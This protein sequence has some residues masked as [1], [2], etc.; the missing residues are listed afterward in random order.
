MPT[1]LIIDDERAIRNVLKDILSNEGFKVEEA[2]DGEEGLKKFQAGS[3]DVVLCDIKMPKLDGIEFLQKVMETGT[4]IPVI[5]ISGH[6]NIETAVDAVKKGAFDY[7]SKPPDL[8]RL[9][10]TIRN[11]M[12]KTTLVQETKVLKR[13]VSKV[14]EII[15]E[16]EAILRI[17]ETIEKVAPTD[18]RVLVTGGNGSGKELVARWLH[19]KS[20]RS[21]GPLVEVNC[22]AIPGELIES[23]L[24]GHEKGSFTSAIK[25]RIGKFEQAS[26]GTLFLDE[27]GDMSLSAQAKVLRALQEGKITRVGGDKEISVDVRVVAATNKDLLKEV[28]EKNFRLDLYH[29]LG[30]ILIHVPSL[31]ERRDDIPSLVDKFLD[32]IAAEY[33]QAKK[34]IDKKALDILKN[35]NWTGNIRELRNVVERLVILSGKEITAADVSAYV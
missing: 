18:A 11:A 35:H 22:A 9:L 15:G 34:G 2:A 13:K 32:D 17:K 28:E 7:I 27:I 21:S 6:G 30:V 29:R 24:F 23:E 20:N 16:S 19:E 25:Q 33:G 4:D 5:M 12:D 1:I 31:N 26:G 3:F 10:I 14:Q 8:N